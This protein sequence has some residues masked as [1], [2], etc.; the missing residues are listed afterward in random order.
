MTDRD[1]PSSPH[2]RDP[3]AFD[4]RVA[5][6]EPPMTDEE[7]AEA[8]ARIR[9]DLEREHSGR[10]ERLS[11]WQTGRQVSRSRE[12]EVARLREEMRAN[13]Y[14]EKGYVQISERGREKWV[15]PEEAQ[16]RAKRRGGRSHRASAPGRPNMIA[17]YVL[18]VVVA[19]AIGAMLVR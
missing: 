11:H 12:A 9:E 13:F 8:L 18:L 4:P 16:W 6:E 1:R 3:L 5:G 17:I 7:R 19:A 10:I 15:P 14:K 2:A